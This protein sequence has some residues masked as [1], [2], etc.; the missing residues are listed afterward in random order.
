MSGGGKKTVN[1]MPEGRC[2]SDEDCTDNNVCY[3]E[4]ENDPLGYCVS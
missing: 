3:R 2:Y 1:T 4:N